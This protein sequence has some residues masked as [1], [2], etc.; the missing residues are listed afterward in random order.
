[1]NEEKEHGKE[2]ESTRS[3]IMNIR[4]AIS[5]EE[6]KADTMKSVIRI[7]DPVRDME[8]IAKLRAAIADEE[9]HSTILRNALS[10]I[11]REM[12]ALKTKG[13]A[14]TEE[15]KYCHLGICVAASDDTK[16]D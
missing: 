3:T 13:S 16:N 15:K 10:E 2:F 11:E 6:S 8:T 14:P 9:G 7:M 12:E 5:R 1:M 4:T